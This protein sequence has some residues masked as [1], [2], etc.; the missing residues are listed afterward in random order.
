M[1]FSEDVEAFSCAKFACFC[2]WIERLT[3]VQDFPINFPSRAP[4]FAFPDVCAK[5]SFMFVI[6]VVEGLLMIPE[7]GLEVGGAPHVLLHCHRLYTYI[8]T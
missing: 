1:G 4:C 6:L 7:P 2:H 5:D 3:P 8:Y